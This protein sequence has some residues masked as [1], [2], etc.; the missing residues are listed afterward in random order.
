M[1]RLR[2][3][4]PRQLTTITLPEVNASPSVRVDESYRALVANN[5]AGQDSKMCQEFH[6]WWY[7]IVQQH[8][9]IAK[10]RTYKEWNHDVGSL[11]KE[12]SGQVD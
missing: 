7:R 4:L 11:V 8:R 1:S 3:S 12:A 5:G 6:I 2:I 10:I 9:K